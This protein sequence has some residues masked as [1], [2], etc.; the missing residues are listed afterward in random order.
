MNQIAGISSCTQTNLT[1]QNLI[2]ST[3]S[4]TNVANNN[5]SKQAKPYN[6]HHNLKINEYFDQINHQ[7]STNANNSNIINQQ[8]TIINSKLVKAEK[9]QIIIVPANSNSTTIIPTKSISSNINNTTDYEMRFDNSNMTKTNANTNKTPK[10][11]LNRKSMKKEN[12][13][14]LNKTLDP[15]DTINQNLENN[16]QNQTTVK[17]RRLSQKNTTSTLN[18]SNKTNN[19]LL[20]NDENAIDNIESAT[21]TSHSLVVNT[22]G[23]INNIVSQ[24][25]SISSTTDQ[26][27]LLEE[28]SSCSTFSQQDEEIK[29]LLMMKKS[30]NFNSQISQQINN[31]GKLENIKNCNGNSNCINFLIFYSNFFKT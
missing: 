11:S 9:Q 22:N 18:N 5:I 13:A 30:N 12:E 21:S 15:I 28:H 23:K 20:A 6:S 29:E 26:V 16:K 19:L 4:E 10:T 7:N 3:N 8:P 2:N 17:R 31:K 27:Q 25:S 1:I 24:G 14:I